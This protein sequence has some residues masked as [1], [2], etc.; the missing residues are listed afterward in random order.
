MV[1]SCDNQ[2]KCQVVELAATYE[3]RLRKGSKVVFHLEAFVAK[4]MSIY[5]HFIEAGFADADFD[6][7]D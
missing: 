5:A 6:Q 4:F 3:H 2:L 1:A 7:E